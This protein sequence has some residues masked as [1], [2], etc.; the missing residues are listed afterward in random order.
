VRLKPLTLEAIEAYT[1]HGHDNAVLTAPDLNE[2]ASLTLA[3]LSLLLPAVLV[4]DASPADI[5]R[6]SILSAGAE[7]IFAFRDREAKMLKIVARTFVPLEGAGRCEF[8]VFRGGDG[9]RD[10]IAVIV[11]DPAPVSPVPVRIHSACLTGDLF[12]SLKCDCGEQL[13]GT[14]QAMSTQNGGIVLYLDQEGRGN[15][16][17]NKIRA[18]DLQEQGFDTYDADELLGF[19]P[20][21][22]RFD[23]AGEM[24]KQLGF[25][26]VRLMTNNPHKIAA[27]RESGLEVVST[28]RVLTR[29]T[30]HNAKYLAAKRDK[31]GHLLGD[32]ALDGVDLAD[33]ARS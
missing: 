30:A 21:Q 17:A 26:S 12:G 28:H 27:L 5:E 4:T 20:D 6:L 9:F 24:L 29:P 1:R 13:R 22:R 8:V 31:G 25:T 14:V 32:A 23:F 15:G 11:G 33:V 16:I 10:Q 18:Y 3:N 19:G 2:T 7:D